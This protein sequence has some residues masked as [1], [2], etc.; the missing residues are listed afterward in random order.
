[1]TQEKLTGTLEMETQVAPTAM[2]A[3]P[4]SKLTSLNATHPHILIEADKHTF[5]R[6]DNNSTIIPDKRL[7]SNHCTLERQ[8]KDNG[9]YTYFVY[10]TSSNGTYV[11]DMKIGKGEKKE[12]QN[13]DT[14]QLL[15]A[16]LV[17]PTEV[18]AYVF[19]LTDVQSS[20]NTTKRK[21]STERNE[22]EAKRQKIDDAISNEMKCCICMDIIYQ[23]VTAMPC[24][25]N[26]CGGCYSG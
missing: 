19:T 13:G 3:N 26:S 4:W 11:N 16:K 14:I 22:N 1:M 15:S 7:S 25:H 23:A 8:K 18:I 10:D 12:I 17:S 2:V 24:L 6:V 9:D 20:Q 5:G 21:S